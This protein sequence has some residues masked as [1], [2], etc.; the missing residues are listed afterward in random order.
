MPRKKSSTRKKPSTRQKSSTRNKTGAR[1]KSSRKYGATARK[2]V[3]RSMDEM[4]RGKLKSGRSRKKAKSRKQAIAIALN[5]TRRSGGK[6]PERKKTFT[7]ARQSKMPGRAVG[8]AEL[9][10]VPAVRPPTASSIARAYATLASDESSYFSGHVYG[11]K[12]G[13][14]NA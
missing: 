5:E 10:A 9:L 12:G 4:K 11:V 3:K 8:K 13:R 6:V 2:K 7:A 1:T 14:R